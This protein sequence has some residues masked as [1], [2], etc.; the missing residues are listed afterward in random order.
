MEGGRA[1]AVSH[2]GERCGLAVYNNIVS[3]KARLC[4]KHATRAL[5]AG[6]AM[7]Y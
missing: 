6:K 2:A 7:A 3:M 1:A 5:L 4:T